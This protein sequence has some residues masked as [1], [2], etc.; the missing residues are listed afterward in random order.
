MENRADSV[1][2]CDW[3]YRHGPRSLG[4]ASFKTMWN[5]E[6]GMCLLR[7][8]NE[9]DV[10]TDRG[11][12]GACTPRLCHLFIAFV[13]NSECSLHSLKASHH[14]CISMLHFL[15]L[16]FNR[17]GSHYVAQA[18]LK[19]LGSRDPPAAAPCIAAA[20]HMPLCLQILTFCLS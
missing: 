4:W 2:L 8:R 6:Q 5:K 14:L 15:L 18:D 7:Q 13:S 3:N 9:V 19:L 17:W 20:Q 11:R 12:D 16:L 1:I 10:Q